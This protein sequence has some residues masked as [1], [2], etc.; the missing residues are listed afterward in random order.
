[1]KSPKETPCSIAFLAIVSIGWLAMIHG[2]SFFI[3]GI[4][5]M[6]A[7]GIVLMLAIT[8]TSIIGYLAWEFRQSKLV[9][10]DEI[11]VTTQD[12]SLLMLSRSIQ[13]PGQTSQRRTRTRLS[14]SHPMTSR[15]ISLHRPPHLDRRIRKPAHQSEFATTPLADFSGGDR[16]IMPSVN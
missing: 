5:L 2:V 11:S 4:S 3:F 16:R 8:I 1:M 6:A 7:W 13:H 10:A 12:V 14:M 15:I 9:P